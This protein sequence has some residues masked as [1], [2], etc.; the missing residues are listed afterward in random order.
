MV[1]KLITM[2]F[3]SGELSSGVDMP[4]GAGQQRAIYGGDHG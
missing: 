3:I 1:K 2:P 4:K